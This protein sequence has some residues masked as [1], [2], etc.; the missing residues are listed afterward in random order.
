MERFCVSHDCHRL[1]CDVEMVQSI[2]GEWVGYDDASAEIA[3]LRAELSSEKEWSLSLTRSVDAA[4]AALGIGARDAV[5]IAEA[6]EALKRALSA[7]RAA[8]DGE[9]AKCDEAKW[10][11]EYLSATNDGQRADAEAWLFGYRARRAA[12]A[13]PKE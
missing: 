10:F 1:G 4:H 6:V 7:A 3:K 2:V 13:K 9:R 11:I 5:T 8:L 12:E